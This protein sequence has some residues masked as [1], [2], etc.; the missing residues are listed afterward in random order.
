MN[1]S[2]HLLI[3]VA[4]RY[5]YSRQMNELHLIW[6]RYW[7]RW[8]KS[9]SVLKFHG[10]IVAMNTRYRISGTM[11][12]AFYMKIKTNSDWKCHRIPSSNCFGAKLCNIT[13]IIAKLK[14]FFLWFFIFTF[15]MFF[16]FHS[17]LNQNGQNSLLE[18]FEGLVVSQLSL[19]IYKHTSIDVCEYM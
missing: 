8:E 3:R 11:Q 7:A 15:C 19:Y 13:N 16:V 5:G 18:H 12:W 17:I 9:Q 6:S 4:N 2:A 1:A 10:F 14:A